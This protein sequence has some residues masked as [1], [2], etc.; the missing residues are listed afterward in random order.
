MT[1]AITTAITRLTVALLVCGLLP[2][3]ISRAAEPAATEFLET[4]TDRTCDEA[5]KSWMITNTHTHFSVQ[6]KVQWHPVGGTLTEE[7]I[8]LAPQQRR[9]IGC[10]PE[11]QIVS[12]ELMQF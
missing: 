7:T 10:A 1:V 2:A 6:V 11:L 5:N 9:P 8:V 12:A 3:S 4:Y